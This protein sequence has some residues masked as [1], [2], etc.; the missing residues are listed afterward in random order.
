[1][2]GNNDAGCFYFQEANSRSK[3]LIDRVGYRNKRQ[4]AC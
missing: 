4:T 1:M 2:G 3:S